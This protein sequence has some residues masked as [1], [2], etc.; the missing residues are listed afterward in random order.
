MAGDTDTSSPPAPPRPWV[1]PTPD[2]DPLEGVEWSAVYVKP[3]TPYDDE[4]SE[5]IPSGWW[6]RGRY[7]DW[8]PLDPS[9]FNLHIGHEA[10]DEHGCD[11]S[12]ALAWRTAEALN[13]VEPGDR[14]AVDIERRWR[15]LPLAYRATVTDRLDGQLRWE[16]TGVGYSRMLNAGLGAANRAR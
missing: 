6:V 13:L 12:A 1:C 14:Y 9:P 3:G 16:R 10:F 5:F 15:F 7:R 4:P 2:L 8:D 11:V